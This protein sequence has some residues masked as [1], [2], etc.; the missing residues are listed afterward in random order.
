MVEDLYIDYRFSQLDAVE[1]I[2][3]LQLLLTF[4]AVK[5]LYIS[6]EFAPGVAAALQELVGGGMAEVLPSLRN[7]S[8]DWPRP[9]GPPPLGS[10]RENIEQFVAARRLSGQPVAFSVKSERFW[11]A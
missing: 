2:L 3:W 8:V 5:N 9:S 11:K 6:E 7:M 4:T 10:F 1:N